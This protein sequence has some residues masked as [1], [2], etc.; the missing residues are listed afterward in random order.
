MNKKI[1]F[2]RHA[3]SE[4][5]GTALSDHDRPLSLRGVSNSHLMG[6]KLLDQNI[7][8]DIFISSSARRALETCKI[9]KNELK[10]ESKT[11]IFRG[12]YSGGISGIINSI[13][14]ISN[15][16]NFIAIF[17]HNPTMHL[18]YNEIALDSIP[19]L[20]TSSLF[21]GSLKSD[22]WENFS[23]SNLD[24]KSYEHLRNIKYNFK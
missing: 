14:S 5:G 19:K 24:I 3:K 17:G 16:Y 9:I 20:P 18:I 15:K 8:P 7:I 11:E 1:L 13:Q 4:W 12:I 6:K 2:S 21:I 10:I 23:L 22:S